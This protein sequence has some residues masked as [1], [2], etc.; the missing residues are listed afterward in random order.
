[1]NNQYSITIHYGVIVPVASTVYVVLPLACAVVMERPEIVPVAT[2]VVTLAVCLK[3]YD[4][5]RVARVAVAAG[6]S[7][8]N[9][10]AAV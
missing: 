8:K 2:A 7:L 6:E 3:P 9:A 1:M 10:W 5:V 4:A